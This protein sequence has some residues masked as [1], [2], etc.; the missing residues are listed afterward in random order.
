MYS[1]LPFKQQPLSLI[2]QLG[3]CAFGLAKEALEVCACW[4]YGCVLLVETVALIHQTNVDTSTRLSVEITL[5][6]R[7]CWS[8]EAVRIAQIA[9]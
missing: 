6:E 4:D 1:S 2:S 7:S 5:R 3:R 8:A 9:A